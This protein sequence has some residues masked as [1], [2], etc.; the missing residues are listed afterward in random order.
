[1]IEAIQNFF[2]RHFTQ[3]ATMSELDA[4]LHMRR[5]FASRS[6]KARRKTLKGASHAHR[7]PG[8]GRRRRSYLP[9]IIGLITK[10]RRLRPACKF[11]YARASR[12]ATRDARLR[13][14]S[15]NDRIE[16]ALQQKRLEQKRLRAA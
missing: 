10:R 13:V 15:N 9:S 4:E 8:S 1:V 14:I 3:Q 11:V 12:Q 5:P 16:N 2:R 7:A 6:P